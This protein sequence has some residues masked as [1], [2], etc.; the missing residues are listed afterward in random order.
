[1][2]TGLLELDRPKAWPPE[3][4]A[5]LGKHY[6]L[7]LGWETRQ[8]NLSA[9][10]YD[11]AL[12]GL[13]DILQPY[14]ILGW[15]CTRLTVAEADDILRSGMQMPDAAMLARRIDALVES[16]EFAPDLACLLKSKNQSDEINRAGMVWFCFFPPRKAGEGGIERFFRYWGGEALYNSHEDDPV[17]SPAI[18][19]IGT[20]CIVESDVPVSSLV[21]HERLALNIVRRF[22]A[23][24]D[25]RMT[26]STDYED[27]IVRPLTATN[28]RRV[29][30]FPDPDFFALTGCAEWRR[31]LA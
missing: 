16:N 10:A 12:R 26:E 19:V 31:L 6:D 4:C 22:L 30:R 23:S 14:V 24:R 5:F 29:I 20:P 27:R 17:T 7:F 3:L 13:M 18:R 8:N 21:R 25:H 11:G 15:H 2:S 9:P 28:V 1:M